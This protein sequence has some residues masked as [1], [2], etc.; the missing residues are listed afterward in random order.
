MTCIEEK[1]NLQVNLSIIIQEFKDSNNPNPAIKLYEVREI[2][3]A[4][5]YVIQLINLLVS[6][7]DYLLEAKHLYSQMKKLSLS[8]FDEVTLKFE[9]NPYVYKVNGTEDARLYCIAENKL[10]SSFIIYGGGGIKTT[11]TY[12]QDPNLHKHVLILREVSKFLL[13]NGDTLANS[14]QQHLYQDIPISFTI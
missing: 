3:S 14:V 10:K 6:T 4:E 13:K 12:Q 9:K 1:L 5:S 8:G 7:S 11:R 2:R